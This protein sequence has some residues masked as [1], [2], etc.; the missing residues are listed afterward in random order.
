MNKVKTILLGLGYMG[1][2]HLNAL[3]EHDGFEVAYVLEPGDIDASLLPATALHIRSLDELNDESV[4]CAV[5]ATPTETHFAVGRQLLERGLC[6]LMEKPAATTSAQASS[7]VA[8]ANE[9]QLKL[10]AGNIERCNPATTVLVDVLSSG[11]LGRPVH[12]RTQRAGRFP[13]AVKPGNDVVLDLAVHDFD[14]L[15]MLFGPLQFG[16]GSGGIT[17][18]SGI[19]DTAEFLFS[20]E[21]GIFGSVHVNWLTPQKARSITITG[22]LANC[23]VDLINQ[24]CDVFGTELDKLACDKLVE[25]HAAIIEQTD[26]HKKLSIKAPINKALHIQLSEFHAYLRGEPT[27]LAT[28][29]QLIESVEMVEKAGLLL[30]ESMGGAQLMDSQVSWKPHF[31]R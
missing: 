9:R 11:I 15:R 2:N 20:A 16:H 6:V 22:S 28:G 8:M 24:T 10:A 12:V 1:R 7:L 25:E 27:R 13:G 3:Q 4:T 23:T 17:R 26:T 30:K 21:D 14:I 18:L 31:A 5:V 19:Y 29:Q